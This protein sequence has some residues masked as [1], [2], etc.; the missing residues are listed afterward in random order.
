MADAKEG[1]GVMRAAED[2]GGWE[3][4]R[5]AAERRRSRSKDEEHFSRPLAGVQPS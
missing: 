2:V 5:E 3:E 4:S 1:P